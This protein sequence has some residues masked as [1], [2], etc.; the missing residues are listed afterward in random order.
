MS[1]AFLGIIIA[2]TPEFEV[3]MEQK[4]LTREYSSREGLL[5]CFYALT[6]PATPSERYDMHTH[7]NTVEIYLFCG[8]DLSFAF[9]GKRYPVREGSI[10]IICPNALHRPIVMSECLYERRRVHV[11]K[12]LFARYD[13]ANME[14]YQRLRAEQMI[15]L[16]PEEC[17]DMGAA[18]M[19][20]HIEESLAEAT[21]LGDLRATIGVLSLL[22]ESEKRTAAGGRNTAVCGNE[23]IAKILAY[24]A[25][26]LG[27]DLSY[28]SLAAKFFLSEKAL[29]RLFC[30]E[31]G[32]T[33]NEYVTGKRIAKAESVL[34]AGGSAAEAAAQSGF[35]DYSSFYRSFIREVGVS[36]SNFVKQQGEIL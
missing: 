21:A 35:I 15:M 30:R 2:F 31:V 7:R 10:F 23:K 22:I 17:Q 6:N 34:L 28:K 9:E 20:D 12:E 24:I 11:D 4:T 16:S 14:L 27:E 5:R 19:L 29:Y 33:L 18:A 1:I 3:Y 26:N 13:T 25:A 36:P 8:G 32:F